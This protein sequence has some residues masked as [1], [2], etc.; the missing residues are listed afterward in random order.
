MLFSLGA[1]WELKKKIKELQYRQAVKTDLL[2]RVPG[3]M[4]QAC[5][6]RG[7][8]RC[9]PCA[10]SALLALGTAIRFPA[11]TCVCMEKVITIM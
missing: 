2:H 1:E 3:P 9:F 7:V 10:P 5:P 4:Q 11:Q 6:A 8:W